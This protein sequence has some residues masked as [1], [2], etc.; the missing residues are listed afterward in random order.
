MKDSSFIRKYVP[1]NKW[2]Q[3]AV[4][5]AV[6]VGIICLSAFLGLIVR[7]DLSWAAV[8]PEFKAVVIRY[9][10]TYITGTLAVFFVP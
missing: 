9:L 8:P 3:L 7:F 4:L 1:K 5:L 6:D 2:V 10:P